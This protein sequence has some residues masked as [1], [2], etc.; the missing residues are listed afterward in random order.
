MVR[1]Q[2][3]TGIAKLISNDRGIMVSERNTFG[4]KREKQFPGSGTHAK[5]WFGGIGIFFHEARCLGG[6]RDNGI[7]SAHRGA[8]AGGHANAIGKLELHSGIAKF[9]Y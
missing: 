8:T 3:H 7:G 6:I 1:S 5:S 9:P 4:E 2:I